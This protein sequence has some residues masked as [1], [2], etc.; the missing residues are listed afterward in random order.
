MTFWRPVTWAVS[1]QH[2]G[3][4]PSATRDHT[5][6][7]TSLRIP[8]LTRFSTIR[9]AASTGT[10]K[11]SCKRCRVTVASGLCTT[12]STIA[13]TIWARR[14]T[15][16][17]SIP[18]DSPGS[19]QGQSQYR[20]FGSLLHGPARPSSPLNTIADILRRRFRCSFMPSCPKA[21]SAEMGA[22][23]GGS[24]IPF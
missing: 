10:L 12:S 22:D 21:T 23:V 24:F 9:A 11:A 19:P 1:R 20:E 15:P 13:C 5:P 14:W 18:I 3:G 6:S 2:L 16:R 17:C 8:A 4:E 7:R